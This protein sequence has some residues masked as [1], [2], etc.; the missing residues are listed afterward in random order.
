MIN[1]HGWKSFSSRLELF[2]CSSEASEKKKKEAKAR[3]RKREKKRKKRRGRSSKRFG[4]RS[5]RLE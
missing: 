2:R 4:E 1:T 5:L 3:R